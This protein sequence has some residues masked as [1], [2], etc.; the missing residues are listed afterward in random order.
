[1]MRRLGE[2]LEARKRVYGRADDGAVILMYHRVAEVS[3]DPWGLCVSPANFAA[4]LEILRSRASPT[5]LR[6]L[7]M[8]RGT[9]SWARSVVVTLDDGY[10]D[11]V[12]A[13]NLLLARD[14]PATV[15][16]TTGN[17]GQNREFWWDE[18]NRYLLLPGTLPATLELTI[19]GKTHRWHL[20]G[21]VDYAE[22]AYRSNRTLLAFQAERGTRHAL[23]YSIWKLLVRLGHEE[24]TSILAEIGRWAGDRGAARRGYRTL[25]S[26]EILAVAEGGL[27]DIGA[28][29]VTHPEMPSRSVGDQ[30]W[31]IRQSRDSLQEILG[32]PLL[33]FSYPHGE[34]SRATVDLVAGA[35]F[36]WACTAAPGTARPGGNRLR[37]PRYNVLDWSADEFER[38]LSAWLC[39]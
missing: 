12:D 29:T 24:R 34:H 39:G 25:T 2:F 10:V 11:A 15:F 7:A 1:M 36:S 38:R 17:I 32:R 28:H 30:E 33:S 9:A 23:Y 5:P 16:V 18:L 14:V 37:L 19:A 4:H 20:G 26:D 22:D 35:G 27:V 8:G 3:V 21:A 6:R 31:E 13:A